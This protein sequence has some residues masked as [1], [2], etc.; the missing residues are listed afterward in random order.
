MAG[1]GPGVEVPGGQAHSPSTQTG[2]CVQGTRERSGSSRTQP[3]GTQCCEHVHRGCRDHGLSGRHCHIPC[4]CAPLRLLH[5][6]WPS[7]SP[8]ASSA[9]QGE[10]AR[11]EASTPTPSKLLALR[12]HQ[13]GPCAPQLGLH[14]GPQISSVPSSPP[15]V[16]VAVPLADTGMLCLGPPPS[17]QVLIHIS[18]TPASE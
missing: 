16:L 10:A 18:H 8:S 7:S 4:N 15:Q 17:L 9:G 11:G 1:Q 3:R 6:E 5:P 2:P 13:Q 12:R 14:T